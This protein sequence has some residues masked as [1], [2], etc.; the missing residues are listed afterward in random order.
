MGTVI[1]L[2]KSLTKKVYTIH[3]GHLFISFIQAIVYNVLKPFLG[4][5]GDGIVLFIAIVVEILPYV[6]TAICILLIILFLIFSF[7][8]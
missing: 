4:F 8:V 2:S 7:M 3:I 5:I 6:F 1:Y